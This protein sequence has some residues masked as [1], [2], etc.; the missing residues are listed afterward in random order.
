VTLSSSNSVD[1]FTGKVRQYE[2]EQAISKDAVTSLENQ[3]K[4]LE[5]IPKL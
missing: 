5:G 3:N 4:L 2:E 1:L